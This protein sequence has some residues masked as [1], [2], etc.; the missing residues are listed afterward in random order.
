METVKQITEKVDLASVGGEQMKKKKECIH[1]FVRAYA[2]QGNYK[3]DVCRKCGEQQNK[4]DCC[5]Y[6]MNGD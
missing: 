5:K 4:K 3:V 2:C 1:E 6:C